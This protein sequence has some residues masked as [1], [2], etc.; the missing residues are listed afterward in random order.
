[1]C[2]VECCVWNGSLSE[3]N[4]GK[5]SMLKLMAVSCIYIRISVF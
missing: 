3:R 5:K 2:G 1:M 4:V